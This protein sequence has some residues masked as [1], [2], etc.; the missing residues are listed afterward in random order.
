MTKIANKDE[1][2]IKVIFD[3][4]DLSKLDIKIDDN[5][6]IKKIRSEMAKS[7]QGKFYFLKLKLDEAL[8]NEVLKKIDVISTDI[9]NQISSCAFDKCLLKSDI[10][11]IILNAA[12]LVDRTKKDEFDSRVREIKKKY[13]SNGVTIH[14]SG[15][16]APYSFC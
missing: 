7:S 5:T 16:W 6:E 9:Y 4:D 14:V 8:R 10:S 11:Q 15:P 12:Y 2:G 3:K 1:Y 13:E